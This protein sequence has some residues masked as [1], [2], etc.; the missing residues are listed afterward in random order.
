[1]IILYLLEEE[2]HPTG[3]TRGKRFKIDFKHIALSNM[4]SATLFWMS[5]VSIPYSYI[6]VG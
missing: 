2:Q 5:A 6:I 3:V 4:H 1:M